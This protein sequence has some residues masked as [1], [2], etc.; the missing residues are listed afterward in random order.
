M[1]TKLLISGVVAGAVAIVAANSLF[2]VHET[3]QAMVLQLGQ[4]RNVVNEPGLNFKTPFVQNVIY[5]DRRV[6]ETD[7][8]PE[9]IQSKDKEP[10]VV[11]SYTR[12]R[13]TDVSKFF[14]TVR[15][16]REARRRLDIIVNSALRRKLA[17]HSSTEIV[18]G[19]RAQ[20]M[21]DILVEARQQAAPLGI[22]V[23]DVRIK[24]ADWPANISRAVYGRMNEERHKE[25]KEIRAQGEEAAKEI[26]ATADKERTILLAEAQRDAQKLRGEGD[27]ESIR[28]TADAFSKDPEFY[29]FM[30]S[31]EAYETALSGGDTMMVLDPNVEFLKH[32]NK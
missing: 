19:D 9:E 26:R 17:Q 30:R 1:A 15:T 23:V 11:D 14:K 2:T 8:K 6:L 3:E 28:I 29:G 21:D 25:A 12:W 10:M 20:I 24:R 22:D 32:F 13:I 16:E 4:V 31:L 27:A 5:F 7:S 18:S